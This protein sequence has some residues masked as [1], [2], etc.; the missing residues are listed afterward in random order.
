[1]DTTLT[2]KITAGARREGADI[3]GVAP[4][5]AFDGAPD[6]H[7]PQ[8]ILRGAAS[9]VVLGVAYSAASFENAPSREYAIAYKVVNREV[10]R[11]AFLVSR[12][13]Q[14]EGCRA[15]QV[16]ASPPYDMQKNRGDLSHKHAAALAGIGVF[17]KNDLL[18]TPRF[19]ARLRLV[20][21]ITEARLAPGTP[22]AEDLC[23][24]CD[25]CIR[26]CPAMA[27]KGRRVVDKT[28]C[29]QHHIDIGRR[30]QLDD[31]EQ[32]CGVCIRV[33]PVGT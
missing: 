8:D 13:L 31:W 17:G 5:A 4:A 10:D 11:L 33:C 2:Q 25:M 19:G 20:S 7:R 14:R 27:L 22:L 24:E 29:N 9:V 1:M 12:L 28:A 6:G 16:P 21:V 26:A 32:I 23:G 30:L 3:V 18:L 15:L